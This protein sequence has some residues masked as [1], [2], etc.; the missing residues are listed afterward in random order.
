MDTDEIY[1]FIGY[2]VA[3]IF[4]IYIISKA[5]SLNVRVI[6]GLTGQ[7]DTSK[8]DLVNQDNILDEIK[9]LQKT[10]DSLKTSF[11][12]DK[13]TK[14]NYSTLLDNLYTVMNYRLLK[15]IIENSE[16]I[17]SKPDDPATIATIKKINEMKE[18]MDTLSFSYKT[19]DTLSSNSTSLN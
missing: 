12:I 1:K 6:E 11:N 13:S 14:D 3:V 4:F 15:L 17:N 16:K 18:F 8:T 7:N 19:L 2:A 9:L 5:L 10:E